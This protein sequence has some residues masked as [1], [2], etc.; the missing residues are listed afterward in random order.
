MK[1]KNLLLGLVL[2]LGF[3]GVG[4]GASLASS[5]PLMVAAEDAKS[6]GVYLKGSFNSWGTDGLMYFKAGTTYEYYITQA[7]T[8]GDT[9]KVD[10]EEHSV[11]VNTLDSAISSTL[12]SVQ[13]SGD[14]NVVCNQTGL[15]KLIYV[16]TS[17]SAHIISSI[18]AQSS[19]SVSEYKVID[20]VVGT[21]SARSEVADPSVA[22]VPTA[23]YET[24]K[25]FDG[26]YTDASCSTQYTSAVLT[27]DTTLYAKYSTP[28]T[29]GQFYFGATGR[30]DVY[31]YTY[32]KSQIMGAFPGTKLVDAA[33]SGM[34]FDGK[35]LY[36]VSIPGGVDADTKIIFSDYTGTTKNTQ[37]A[38][39][40][41]NASR[42]YATDTASPYEGDAAKFAAADFVKTVVDKVDAATD[43]SVCNV[44]QTD[45]ST[46][47]TTY[48]GLS[49]DAQ[50]AVNGATLYTWKDT[51]KV[52]TEK[53]NVN[54]SGLVAQLTTLAGTSGTPAAAIGNND[55]NLTPVI[56][57]VIS[58][59]IAAIASAGLWLSRRKER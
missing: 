33:V 46:L 38:D 41:L 43:A 18:E 2:S 5:H 7:M 57:M 50:T 17:S 53:L 37:T 10:D 15:Y 28:A 55:S 56:I 49:A 45:A 23:L 26:W 25:T 40:V 16:Y 48:N 39:Y 35:G 14:Y 8:S 12:F 24:G 51:N 22:F 59:G 27:N 36:S 42:Y 32:G 29:S 58:L 3:A 44:S 31:V 30:T 1:K 6:T 52:E 34:N 9:F 20:G 13:T 54:F 47:M 19:Y 11:W 4:L 21:T